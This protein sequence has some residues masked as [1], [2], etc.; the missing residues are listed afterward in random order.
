M[1]TILSDLSK[2]FQ[3]FVFYISL[4]DSPIARND[5]DEQVLVIVNIF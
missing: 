1:A 2:E 5:F 4:N 3:I